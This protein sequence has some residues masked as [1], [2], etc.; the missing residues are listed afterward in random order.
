MRTPVWIVPVL[1]VVCTAAGV[2]GSRLLEAPSV[3]R[4][5][6]A[7]GPHA[8][9]RTSVFVVSGVKCVDTAERAAGQLDGLSGVQQLAAFASRARL[10]VTYDPAVL[11]AAAIRAALEGPVLEPATGAFLFGLYRVIEMDGVPIASLDE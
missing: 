10:D 2:S 9:S 8:G 4:T 5:W 3:T 1:L 11:D 7:A 6:Q